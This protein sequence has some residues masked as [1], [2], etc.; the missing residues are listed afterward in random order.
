[1]TIKRAVKSREISKGKESIITT[2][3]SA[4]LS[5]ATQNKNITI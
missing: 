4:S 1:M 3:K 5:I 2:L